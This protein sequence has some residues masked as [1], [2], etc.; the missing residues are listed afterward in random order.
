MPGAPVGAPSFVAP[1]YITCPT[2]FG[3]PSIDN[4]S[5]TYFTRF[6]S[7]VSTAR[8]RE[9]NVRA[10]RSRSRKSVRLNDSHR[11][12][13]RARLYRRRTT[14]SRRART[15]RM[16]VLQ[17]RD[18]TRRARGGIARRRRVGGGAHVARARVFSTPA[19]GTESNRVA[20]SRIECGRVD[21]RDGRC[22]CECGDAESIDR[23]SSRRAATSRT[24]TTK[25]TN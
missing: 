1:V 15:H 8:R 6:A 25:S 20:S 24:S 17:I 22:G 11:H 14:R 21:A 19:D 4:V 3:S 12:H 2:S 7:S 13:A 5:Y 16:R 23:R 9:A 18:R 10:A